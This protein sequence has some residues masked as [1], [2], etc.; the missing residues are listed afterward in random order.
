MVV[1]KFE[2]VTGNQFL[3]IA[4]DLDVTL[5][6]EQTPHWDRYD[7]AMDDREPWRKLVWYVDGQPR[8][9]ISLSLYQDTGF[10]YLWAKKGPIWVGDKP[11]AA[12]EHAFR[13]Q[14]VAG[15]KRIDPLIVFVRLHTWHEADD[16]EDLLQ[17]MGYDRT[18]VIKLAGL[19][20][21]QI[22][23]SFDAKGRRA[24][25]QRLRNPALSATDDTDKAMDVFDQRYEI[26]EETADRDGFTINPRTTY[27]TMLSMLGPKYC[28]LYTARLD[29]EPVSWAI[30]T[31]HGK[32]SAYYY[33]A[34]N[35]KGRKA[36]ASDLLYYFMACSLAKEGA[37]YLDLMGIDSPRAPEL[38]GVGRFKRKYSKEVT[39][40]PGPW[41]VPVHPLYYRALQGAKQL[42]HKRRELV[43]DLKDRFAN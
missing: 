35:A 23:K 19:S 38:A 42:R 11:T 17:T 37:H 29:G 30:A 36:G 20:D 43:Q 28:K 8:A 15:V 22:L 7:Q 25:R 27:Q 40:V 14:L 26:L 31:I 3:Q 34:S 21:D 41:D 9:M 33:G 13:Q 24:V 32:D 2:E 6:I 5:P 10:R 4:Q 18:V 1:G 16:L 12:E 39:E